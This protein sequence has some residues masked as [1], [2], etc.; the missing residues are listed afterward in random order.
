MTTNTEPTI[1]YLTSGDFVRDPEGEVSYSRWL[2]LSDAWAGWIDRSNLATIDGEAASPWLQR[3]HWECANRL[4]AEHRATVAAL[5]FYDQRIVQ[6]R[7]HITTAAD[8]LTGLT[9]EAGA[10]AASLADD[11]SA[12]ISDEPT[13]V[14]EQGDDRSVVRKR[15]AQ[16]RAAALQ[17]RRDALAALRH[18]IDRLREAIIQDQI[19]LRTTLTDRHSLWS[20]LLVRSA[21]LIAHYGRRASTY[22]RAA[23]RRSG[24]LVRTPTAPQPDWLTV[25]TIP[26]VPNLVIASGE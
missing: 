5:A 22:V 3:L 16:R 14:A 15:N 26:P 7:E 13:T 9:A 8:K 1:S 10:S 21:H 11:E 4:E 12:P 2:R 17:P 24:G 19:R 18:E 25:G 23:T 20:V 6:L